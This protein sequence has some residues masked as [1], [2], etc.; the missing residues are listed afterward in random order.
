MI[1]TPP[2]AT[3]E[4]SA[5]VPRTRCNAKLLKLTLRKLD[6]DITKWKTFSPNGKLFGTPMR[7]LYV[8]TQTYQT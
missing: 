7:Q 5:T 2:A 6:G 3:T 8:A 1:G 4:H